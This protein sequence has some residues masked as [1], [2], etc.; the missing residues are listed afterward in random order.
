MALQVK[1]L[2]GNTLSNDG[3]TGALGTITIDTQARNI[4]IHDSVTAGGHVVPNSEKIAEMI[5]ARVGAENIQGQLDSK[6]DKVT[7]KQLSTEDYTTTEKNKLAGIEAGAEVNDVTT[8]A[9]RVGDIV[10]A[11]ADITGLS[12]ELSSLIPITQK[13][14]AN[15]VATLDSG[16]KIPSSQLPALAVTETYSVTDITARDAL[17]AQ[18]GD[19]AIVTD[20]GDGHTRSY[21]LDDLGAWHEISTPGLV[22]SVAGRIGDVVLT[23]S[24]VGLGNVPNLP[25]AST[26]QANDL[27]SGTTD[28][29]LMSPLK[30]KEMMQSAGF[31]FDSSGNATLDLGTIS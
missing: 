11:I 7:G 24:D 29:A 22:Q 3:F 16:S 14:A 1:F 13:G 5:E 18:E 4:R 2:R 31:S 6:V 17:S 20:S 25:K 28:N 30:T 26:G 19:V 9:G 10:L 23:A 15:G 27:G 8:V 21:I 12:D